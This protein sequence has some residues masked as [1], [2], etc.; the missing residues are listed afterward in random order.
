V[1][2]LQ[3]QSISNKA[4]I[5]S[6]DKKRR[7]PVIPW[8]LAPWKESM[9]MC[10]ADP[11]FRGETQQSPRGQLRILRGPNQHAELM[12]VTGTKSGRS[13][14]Q[15]AAVSSRKSTSERPLAG[16]A[17]RGCRP[18]TPHWSVVP[19][20]VRMQAPI[21]QNGE[22]GLNGHLTHLRFAGVR[23]YF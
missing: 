6:S 1:P 15:I 22:T 10:S 7:Y 14:R 19:V 8:S 18:V 4:E 21:G 17:A 11:P 5:P 20:K 12:R 23:I 16:W 3:P 2:R 9:L 13:R